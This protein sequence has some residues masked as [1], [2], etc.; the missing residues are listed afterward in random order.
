[1]RSSPETMP[2]RHASSSRTGSRN[3]PAGGRRCPRATVATCQ[4]SLRSASSSKARAAARSSAADGDTGRAL[5]GMPFAVAALASLLGIVVVTLLVARVAT[6]ILAATGLS[7]EEARFQARS[8]L[9]GTGFTTSE[10]EYVVNHPLRR[11]VVMVIMLLGNA[12]V[13]AA[14]S[15]LIIGFRPGGTHDRWRLVLLLGGL[16]A[17][18]LLSRSRWFDRRLTLV[19]ARVLRRWT[20]L[21]RRDEATLLALSGDW[22]VAELRVRDRDRLAHRTL[23]DLNLGRRGVRIL[24]ITKPDGRYEG[25]PTGGTVIEP[26]DLLVLYGREPVIDELDERWAPAASTSST[27]S[28]VRPRTGRSTEA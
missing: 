26:G 4:P 24:G 6:V 23:S 10:A 5:A 17:L 12:G 8:A 15:S 14:A 25:D 7:G 2:K 27:T 11:R 13:V 19:I 3:G 9:T 1:M 21:P 20:D 28:P 16:C 18:I 22:A